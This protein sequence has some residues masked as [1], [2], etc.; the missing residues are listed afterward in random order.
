MALTLKL[1]RNHC[2]ALGF[3][4]RFPGHVAAALCAA[5]AMWAAPVNATLVGDTVTVGHYFPDSVTPLASATPPASFIVQAG[6]AD[7][8]TFYNSYPFGYR[9]NV[10]ASSILVS[11]D[12]LNGAAGTFPDDCSNFSGFFCSTGTTPV[13]FNGL[14]VSDLDDSSGNVL[15]SVLVDTNMAGWDSSRLSFG[16]DSVQFDWKGLSFDNSTYLNATL[17]FGA[18]A[19]PIPEPE[20]YAMLLA[21]LGLFGFAARRR[22]LK[23]AAA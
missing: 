6:N 22:K 20:T 14:G 18:V 2:K 13:S 15:Q 21:G 8:Y 23:L 9:V 16:N 10:E 1:V 19:A 5:G 12:Y 3:M 7:T 4:T 17:S 11:F